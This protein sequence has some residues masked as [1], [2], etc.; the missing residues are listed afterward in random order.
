MA[1]VTASTMDTATG[2][3]GGIQGTTYAGNLSTASAASV[4]DSQGNAQSDALNFNALLTG[5]DTQTITVSAN[6]SNGAQQALGITLQNST[7]TGGLQNARN[8][9]EALNTINSQLQASNISALQ[10]VVAVKDVSSGTEQIR[11]LSTDTSFSIGVGANGVST[12]GVTTDKGAVTQSATSAGGST[13]DISNQVSAEN[14]VTALGN[15]IST[16]GNAQAAV[17]KGENL[18]TYA[19]NL[20]QSQ[21]TNLASAESGIR[22]ANLA[23][24]AANLTKAQILIQ[25]GVA[26]LAQA[27]SAPQQLLTLLRGS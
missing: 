27:N 9:D 8:I 7:A 10:N 19:S 16:L 14:A 15:A 24:Q 13:A 25:A 11:F 18:F 22:D 5:S 17:G 3:T 23:Q 1:A 20:A 6:D 26:A 12:N 21:V 4:A 2:F